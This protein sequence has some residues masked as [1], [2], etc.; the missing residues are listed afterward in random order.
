L[1]RVKA[2]TLFPAH[3]FTLLFLHC[4]LCH[5]FALLRSA[6][7]RPITRLVTCFARS[8]ESLGLGKFPANDDEIEERELGCFLV[9]CSEIASMSD[10]RRRDA[11]LS[12]LRDGGRAVVDKLVDA[13]REQDT[14]TRPAV[15]ASKYFTRLPQGLRHVQDGPGNGREF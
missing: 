3:N 1:I 9:A 8:E 12:W 5:A 2:S 6:E 4:L 13:M 15:P 11:V 14:S 10:E 7:V